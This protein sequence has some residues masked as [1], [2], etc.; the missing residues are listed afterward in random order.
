MTTT[1]DMHTQT[2]RFTSIDRQTDITF[3]DYSIDMQCKMGNYFQQGLV[4]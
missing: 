4:I 3:V 2:D 1:T